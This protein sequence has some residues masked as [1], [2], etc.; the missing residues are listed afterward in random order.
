MQL[1]EQQVE[2]LKKLAG[3]PEGKNLNTILL[4]YIDEI[5]DDVINETLDPKAGKAAIGKLNELRG[6]LGSVDQKSERTNPG[7]FV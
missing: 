4:G 6:K 1:T 7:M 3:S 2:L 5:K